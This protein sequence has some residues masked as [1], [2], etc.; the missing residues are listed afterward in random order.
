MTNPINA[1]PLAWPPGWKRAAGHKRGLFVRRSGTQTVRR[2]TAG[3]GAT[4]VLFELQRL[5]VERHE[6]VISTNMK[7]RS[8]GLPR[9]DM[10]PTDAGAV[11]YWRESTGARRCMAIDA[12]ERVADN[13]A[14]IAATLEALRAIARHGGAGIL[15]RAFTGFLALPAPTNGGA[16]PW[17]E[18]LD[19]AP[20][21]T[22]EQIQHAYRRK[23]SAAHL[24]RPGGDNELASALNVAR[25]QGLSAVGG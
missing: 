3:D 20:Q 17:Y 24:D 9:D 10:T 19:V 4:R 16:R 18:L 1:F 2:I 6:I 8:D 15:D 7:L 22:R 21:A 11:V 23:I 5:Q 25:D 14:A 12:Y 13:L